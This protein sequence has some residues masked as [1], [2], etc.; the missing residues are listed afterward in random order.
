MPTYSERLRDPRWQ[1]KRLEIMSRDDFQCCRCRAHE[2]TLN[3]HHCYYVRGNDPW[4]YPDASLLT[5]CE[6]CHEF[7]TRNMNAARDEL[8]Q[9]LAARGKTS[10]DLTGLTQAIND[11]DGFNA[12]TLLVGWIELGHD[13]RTL[14]EHLAGLYSARRRG[15]PRHG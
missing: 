2:I 12:L 10:E 6:P 1:R 4:E 5:L 7:E 15:E 8:Y 14:A 9:S 3:V 11:P 13:A